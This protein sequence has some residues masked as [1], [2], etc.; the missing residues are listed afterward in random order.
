MFAVK[1]PTKATVAILA[2]ASLCGM[3]QTDGFKGGILPE[4]TKASTDIIA[5]MGIFAAKF[6]QCKHA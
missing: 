5:A 1:M 6:C 3:T 2:L 4:E